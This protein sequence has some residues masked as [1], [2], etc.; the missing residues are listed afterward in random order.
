MTSQAWK[1]HVI[2]VHK[3]GRIKTTI[4]IVRTTIKCQL[5]TFVVIYWAIKNYRYWS[6]D[7]R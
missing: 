4:H 1:Y 3:Y 6:K 5:Y 7:T 2:V